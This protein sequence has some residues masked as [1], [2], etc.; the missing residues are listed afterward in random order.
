MA[1]VLCTGMDKAVLETRKL[2]IE[3]AGHNVVAVT[4]EP[5][6]VDACEKNSFD[7]AVIGQNVGANTKRHIADILKKSCRGVKILE[8]VPL[9]GERILEDAD[10]WM[11]VPA[12][13]PRELG[14]RVTELARKDKKAKA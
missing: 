13:L 6:L 9:H 10:S 1:L 7:V 5:S 3:A 8:L 2:L 14:E 11:V 4:D 12:E